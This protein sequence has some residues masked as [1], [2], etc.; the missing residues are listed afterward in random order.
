MPNPLTVIPLW[1]ARCLVGHAERPE[2]HE[3]D[4]V[5]TFHGASLC[6]ECLTQVIARHI[7]DW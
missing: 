1:C 7:A 6:R 3:K 5:T 2:P 4:A